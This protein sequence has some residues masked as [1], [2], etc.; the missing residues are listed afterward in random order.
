MLALLLYFY[1]LLVYERFLTSWNLS[2]CRPQTYWDVFSLCITILSVLRLLISL[3]PDSDVVVIP[4]VLRD[5][6]HVKLNDIVVISLWLLLPILCAR[7]FL[8]QLR[9]KSKDME[10]R[11]LFNESLFGSESHIFKSC[12]PILTILLTPFSLW[13]IWTIVCYIYAHWT[14]EFTIML[15]A[16]QLYPAVFMFLQSLFQGCYLLWMYALPTFGKTHKKKPSFQNDLREYIYLNIVLIIHCVC[17]TVIAHKDDPSL[18]HLAIGEVFYRLLAVFSLLYLLCQATANSTLPSAPSANDP[19]TD[20]SRS[21]AC[22]I[23]I[24]QDCGSSELVCP[25]PP[26]SFNQHSQMSFLDPQRPPLPPPA[27]IIPEPVTSQAGS[28]STE[29]VT[30]FTPHIQHYESLS[31]DAESVSSLSDTSFSS[32]ITVPQQCTAKNTTCPIPQHIC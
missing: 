20:T 24:E 28:D 2:L 3:Y 21:M 13:Y 5:I 22:A 27:H 29:L 7:T 25:S 30:T 14:V 23:L 12:V 15:H 11:V 17:L 4:Y 19:T 18:Y 8:S 32:S 9:A 31:I 16:L 26:F 6:L 10:F 1:S